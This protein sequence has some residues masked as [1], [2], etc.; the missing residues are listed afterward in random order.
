MRNENA[1]KTTRMIYRDNSVDEVKV[2]RL[3]EIERKMGLHHNATDYCTP[4]G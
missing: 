4:V 2:G 3:S 1:K